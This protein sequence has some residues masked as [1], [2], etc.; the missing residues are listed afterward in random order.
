MASGKLG[1][2][3]LWDLRGQVVNG[4]GITIDELLE[5][6]Y[7][8]IKGNKHFRFEQNS[9]WILKKILDMKQFPLSSVRLMD[10]VTQGT[11]NKLV[12][13]RSQQSAQWREQKQ[14]LC[15]FVCVFSV[16]LFV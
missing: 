8:T 14:V 12:E 2:P 6:Y 1:K 9:K 10:E 3:S 7:S 13:D 16:C 4:V 11:S 15:V 5:K